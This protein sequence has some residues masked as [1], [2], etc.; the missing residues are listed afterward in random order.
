MNKSEKTKRQSLS[1]SKVYQL[2]EPGP[3]VMLSTADKGR[4]NIMV[5]SWHTM[6][7]FEPP[8]I[9]CIVSNRNYSFAALKKNKECT[10]NIPT[11]NILKKVVGC[12]N[13]SGK[14]VD[15]FQ[16]FKLSAIPSSIV[17]PP[18]IKECYANLECKVIDTKLVN[19]YNFF[20]LK[21]IKAWIVPSLKS[22]STIHHRGKGTFMI[23]GKEIKTLSKMK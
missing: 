9:G 10:I 23:A 22:A 3:V 18:L 15:K 16:K 13:C 2:L 6:M 1:L 8:F 4:A 17:K 14:K 7:D 11:V 20:I 19:K 21:V 12:G 5:M